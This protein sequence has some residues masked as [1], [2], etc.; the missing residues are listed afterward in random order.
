MRRRCCGHPGT[1][2]E[3]PS[4]IPRRRTRF[5]HFAERVSNLVGQ[6][7]FFAAC[8][9]GV[10]AWIPTVFAFHSVDTWQLV[11]S[12]V[13]SVLAFLLV[14]LLQNSERRND[15]ALHRKLDA[16]ALALMVVMAQ[17]GEA[18]RREIDREL[19]ELRAAIG[20]EERI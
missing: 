10:I 20:L 9:L 2:P 18:D 3:R 14:T 15:V 1:V 13:T 4:Q 12:T 5:D 17:D 7:A 19:T 6:A 8:L 16:L 11:L